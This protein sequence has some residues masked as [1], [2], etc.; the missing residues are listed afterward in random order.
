MLF[1]SK[2][3]YLDLYTKIILCLLIISFGFSLS[4]SIRSES[5]ISWICWSF[6]DS[7]CRSKI[8]KLILTQTLDCRC[9]H[10]H[11]PLF[12][13]SFA[14]ISMN[15]RPFI[16]K[17]IKFLFELCIAESN[18]TPHQF[19]YKILIIESSYYWNRN[20]KSYFT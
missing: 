2:N 14:W 19:L 8:F 10:V 9:T 4:L 5:K 12:L 7:R 13:V 16:L 11:I 15:L 17:L 1:L 6:Y 18:R 3:L 20:F